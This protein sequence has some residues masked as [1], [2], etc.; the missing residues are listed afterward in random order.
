MPRRSSASS[1]AHDRLAAAVD[2]A[3]AQGGEGHRLGLAHTVGLV[4]RI[5]P[6]AEVLPG[7]PGEAE[8]GILRPQGVLDE[9]HT[10][11]KGPH[12]L[13]KAADGEAIVPVEADDFL[14]SCTCLIGKDIRVD[15]QDTFFL[16]FHLVQP[17]L[18]ARIYGDSRARGAWG[19]GTD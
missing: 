12:G 4:G 16:L 2:D 14:C 9:L 1:V 10:V 15:E 5:E 17:N 18:F 7:I 19:S 8:D 13:G 3:V 11:G 6:P